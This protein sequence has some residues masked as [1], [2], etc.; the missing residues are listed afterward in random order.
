MNETILGLHSKIRG[1]RE[2][3]PN[4]EVRTYKVNP[5]TRKLERVDPPPK[6]ENKSCR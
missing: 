6:A 1:L 2:V 3:G 5:Q 4:S